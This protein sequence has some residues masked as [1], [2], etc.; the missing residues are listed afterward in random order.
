MK[1]ETK[2]CLYYSPSMRHDLS[3]Y[4]RD[5]YTSNSYGKQYHPGYR[6]PKPDASR[7]CMEAL[8]SELVAELVGDGYGK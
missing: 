1:T 4:R 2:S 5:Y 3:E 6:K 7:L 8:L